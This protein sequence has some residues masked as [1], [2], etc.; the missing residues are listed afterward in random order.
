MDRE[1]LEVIDLGTASTETLGDIVGQ[2]ELVTL[3]AGSTGI[4]DD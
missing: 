3:F 4:S 2:P 1:D